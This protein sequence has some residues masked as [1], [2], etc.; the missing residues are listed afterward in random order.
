[1]PSAPV[2]GINHPRLVSAAEIEEQNQRDG[3]LWAVIDGYVV[4][5][6]A[7]WA[8]HPGGLRKLRSANEPGTGAT[9]WA[10]GFSFSRG[11]NAHMPDTVRRFHDGVERYL[12]GGI[13]QAFL[14]PA[15][16]AF[17]PHGNVV[18]LGR[19]AS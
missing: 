3:T 14:P 7:F 17:L 8:S 9:G 15:E 12:N 1:M 6:S 5:A 13:E 11:W 4:D 18:I 2:G 10:F 19:L 16:V